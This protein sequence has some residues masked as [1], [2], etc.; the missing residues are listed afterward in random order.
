[1]ETHPERQS[2]FLQSALTEANPFLSTADCLAWMD[3]HRS[4]LRVR[5]KPV[6]FA[7]LRKWSTNPATGNLEHDSGKFFSIAGINVQTNWGE[8]AEWDQPVIHQPEIGF[9]GIL[10]KRFGGVLYLLMQAKCEPGNLNVVQLSPTLQATKS[11]YTQVHQGSRP[12]YLEYFLEAKRH[13]VLF[14]QLQSEQGARFLRKRNR[15]IIIEVDEEVPVHDNYCWLTLGQLKRLLRLDNAVN[16]DTRTV[17]SGISFGSCDAA[18]MP[19]FLDQDF[20]RPVGDGFARELL[21][22]AVSRDGALH[23]LEDILSWLAGLKAHYDLLVEKIPLREVRHWVRDE[24][25]IHHETGQYFSVLAVE[26]EIEKREV[27]RWC[28][29][30]VKPAQEGIIAFIAR[31]VNGVLHFLVQARIESGNLDVF[32][33]A[34]T[35]QCITGNYRKV[36]AG[37]RPPFLDYVLA[38]RPEQVRYSALLSEEGGRFYHAQNRNLILEVGDEFPVEVPENYMWMTWR[39]LN[40]LIKFNNYVNVEARSLVSTLSFLSPPASQPGQAGGFSASNHR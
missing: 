17:I 23:S 30:I 33:L 9:L 8:V 21:I 19:A 27:T 36:P 31:R 10:T 26:V 2:V 14:D 25:T 11:N 35:V 38:A 4:R 13:R 37:K 34:P 29:P 16:M 15:N 32:E 24:H 12:L 28:Q 18:G 39:Q 6:P 22:S 20:L 40:T 1:M 7:G 3:E 5:I